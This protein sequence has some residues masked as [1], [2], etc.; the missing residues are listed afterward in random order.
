MA[1]GIETPGLA[2]GEVVDQT[3]TEMLNQLLLLCKMQGT[4]SQPAMPPVIPPTSASLPM[5]TP[6]TIEPRE[7]PQQSADLLQAQRMIDEAQARR[8]IN[9]FKREPTPVST[10]IDVPAVNV[11][12]VDVPAVNV[13]AVDVPAVNVAAVD[14]LSADGPTG[15]HV[16]CPSCGLYDF[17][18]SDFC[19]SCGGPLVPG[20]VRESSVAGSSVEGHEED[21]S[22]PDDF[23]ESPAHVQH[24]QVGST[25]PPVQPPVAD[26]PAAA[27]RASSPSLNSDD[28]D[29][30]EELV[31]QCFG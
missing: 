3:G 26:P 29:D 9:A 30:E 25:A 31:L 13:A 18:G 14:D 22:M 8:L 24:G 16:R 12:A 5:A 4:G 15:S 10:T 6:I 1:R 2:D 19:H 28:S 21:E 7:E 27:P 23:T 17:S 20:A 11:A